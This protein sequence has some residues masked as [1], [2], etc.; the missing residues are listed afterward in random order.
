[1][2]DR[3]T[4]VFMEPRRM[5]EGLRDEIA[6]P[7]RQSQASDEGIDPVSAR[8]WTPVWWLGAGGGRANPQEDRS[9]M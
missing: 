4:G 8:G 3:G 2:A 5:R 1:M 6:V 9:S 7:D